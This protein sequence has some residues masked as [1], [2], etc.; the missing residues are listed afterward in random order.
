LFLVEMWHDSD[1]VSVRRLRADG[2]Q[3]VDRS[4][5]HIHDDTVATNH[6]GVA[7]VAVSG[8]RLSLVELGVRPVSFEC[9]C[10][11]CLRFVVVRRDNHLR[12]GSEAVLAMF[13]KDLSDV[14][15]RLV[16]FIDPVFV[17]GDFNDR[18]DR[19]SDPDAGQFNEL[20]AAYG[21]VSRVTTMTHDR[22]GIP[23][24]VATR[25]DLPSPQVDVI[26]VGLSD[27]RLLRWSTALVRPCPIYT[28]AMAQIGR[29]SV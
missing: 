19:P 20:L 12:P 14:L 18:L 6:G 9:L 10:P 5:T 22:G 15:D 23:D 16:T 1:S 3:V 28:S 13:F 11:D 24:T 25:N 27:H 21:L 7:A 17:V 29:C 8:V 4:R 26:D 2:F